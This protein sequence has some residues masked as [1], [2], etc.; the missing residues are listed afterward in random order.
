MTFS[1]FIEE[2]FELA[3]QK[4]YKLT[5]NYAPVI[6][7]ICWIGWIQWSVCS[8][9]ENSILITLD[10]HG[11]IWQKFLYAQ[12]LTKQRIKPMSVIC[13]QIRNPGVTTRELYKPPR[14]ACKR[15][16][17]L[18]DLRIIIHTPKLHAVYLS[19]SFSLISGYKYSFCDSWIEK[20]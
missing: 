17:G 11:R 16:E 14:V 19:G 4:I 5:E 10:R 12:K 1:E 7:E 20:C 9:L 3:Y 6:C 8:V 18:S 15:L 2:L 13:S